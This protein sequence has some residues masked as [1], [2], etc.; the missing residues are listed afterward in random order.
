MKIFRRVHFNFL[1]FP[2]VFTVIWGWAV[3]FYL[4]TPVV[5][6]LPAWSGLTSCLDIV[7]EASLA[8]LVAMALCR[9]FSILLIFLCPFLCILCLFILN[10]LFLSDIFLG[11]SA[12]L[13][14]LSLFL[15]RLYTWFAMIIVYISPFL[16][17]LGL[18]FSIFRLFRFSIAP[19]WIWTF[20]GFVFVAP[21]YGF[22][23]FYHPKFFYYHFI[24]G[25]LA[26]LFMMAL[27]CAAC[28]SFSSESI[29]KD[30]RS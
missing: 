15:M 1:K 11:K 23:K 13:L 6:G 20:G 9:R 22:Y 26:Y 12:H 28:L 5:V 16:A 7:V 19:I 17:S 27:L 21:L 25:Q 10:L 30:E 18:S 24:F 29:Q 3:V 2:E 4:A 14:P 8:A